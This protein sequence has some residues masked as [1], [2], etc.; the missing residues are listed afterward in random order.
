M[1]LPIY[2][3]LKAKLES[4]GLD[5]I[6]SGQIAW[7]CSASFYSFIPVLIFTIY[8]CFEVWSSID[9]WYIFF[10]VFF[11]VFFPI[12][13]L[14]LSLHSNYIKIN[15]VYL[16]LFFLCSAIKDY[17][18]TSAIFICFSIAFPF[19][20]FLV[21]KISLSIRFLFCFIYFLF[22]IAGFFIFGIYNNL[23]LFR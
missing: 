6:T 19:I 16:A 7:L 22:M 13:F 12:L 18:N 1:N 5:S 2:S 3:N 14:L 21:T 10:S 23:F 17:P 11:I 9:Y 8:F 15:L 4:K 20:W